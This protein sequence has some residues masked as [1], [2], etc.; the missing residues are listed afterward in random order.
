MHK[1]IKYF[2]ENKLIILRILAIVLISLVFIQLLNNMYKNRQ[3]ELSKNI[4]NIYSSNSTIDNYYSDYMITQNKNVSKN[5]NENIKETMKQFVDFCNDN[6]IEEAYNMLTDDCKEILFPD[7]E[8]FYNNY[9]SNIF[10]EQKSYTMQAW[11]NEEN[12][13]TFLINYK[14]DLLSTGGVG[15]NIQEYYTFIKQKDNTYKLSINNYIY[16]QNYEDLVTEYDDIKCEIISKYV[17]KDYVEYEFRVYNKTENDILLNGDK[18]KQSL[19]LLDS[20]NVSYSS[21][22][23]EFNN[24]DEIIVTSNNSR[25]F[26]V[27]FNKV[28]NTKVIVKKIVFS[29]IVLNYEEY[30]NA[31]ENQENYENRNQYKF[32]L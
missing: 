14:G 24:N 32:N 12:M 1:I 2:Y 30:K 11:T 31:K 6:D 5:D 8:T 25:K 21:I 13:Y 20:D 9:I 3:R 29:D 17:F 26:R 27:R 4:N 23:S 7:I 19:Y 16:T 15:T 22:K 28:Y 10:T 18:Y